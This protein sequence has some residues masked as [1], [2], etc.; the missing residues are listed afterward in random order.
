MPV[1]CRASSLEE[2]M[3]AG[4]KLAKAELSRCEVVGTVKWKSNPE[5]TYPFKLPVGTTFKLI[6]TQ[7][8]LVQFTEEKRVE[9]DVIQSIN[10]R[11][12]FV[13]SKSASSERFGL[14]NLFSRW[15][16][17]AV[18]PILVQRQALDNFLFAHYQ[19]KFHWIWDV[20]DDPGFQIRQIEKAELNGVPFLK[21]YFC[22][23]PQRTKL[24]T[25]GFDRRMAGYFICDPTRMWAITEYFFKDDEESPYG[26]M[27]K[28]HLVEW[29][30][31]PMPVRVEY[32][33]ASGSVTQDDTPQITSE[34]KEIGAELIEVEY[35]DVEVDKGDFYLSHYG[36]PEP[37]FSN[38]AF[39]GW[40][41]YFLAGTGFLL[42]GILVFRSAKSK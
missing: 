20:F 29:H 1:F 38:R 37:E 18:E 42:G 36:L 15:D 6:G 33:G 16:R 7:F 30:N 9:L 28:I 24:S 21:V 22:F 11:Y 26:A 41:V 2:E 17:A 25:Q 34:W 12:A 39:S 10:D 40:L 23:E 31:L 19:L 4:V 32:Y 27:R 3:R 8:C 35:S 13:I 5:L 14:Q